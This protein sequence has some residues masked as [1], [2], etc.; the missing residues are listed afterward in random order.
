MNE[1][2]KALQEK[3]F[4]IEDAES[5]NMINDFFTNEGVKKNIKVL[6]S[7]IDTKSDD[8]SIF[9]AKILEGVL[10]RLTRENDTRRGN[11][12]SLLKDHRELELELELKLKIISST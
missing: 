6:Q 7:N 4:I 2:Q 3:H 5:T 1:E 12:K 9:N 11:Y 10:E 8:K